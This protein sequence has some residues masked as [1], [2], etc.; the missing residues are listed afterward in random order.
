[1][2]R[3]NSRSLVAIDLQSVLSTLEERRKGVVAL[4][5]QTYYSTKN[6]LF[7]LNSEVN[8]IKRLKGIYILL[9]CANQY[10]SQNIH[11]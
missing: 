4:V 9:K 3:V 7:W 1:M 11:F 8:Y 10:C 6:Q 2:W 5:S